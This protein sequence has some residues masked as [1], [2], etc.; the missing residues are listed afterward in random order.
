MSNRRDKLWR[1]QLVRRVMKF[2]PE[3]VEE[4]EERA[5]VM[6]HHGGLDRIKAETNAALRV[7][8]LRKEALN[9]KRGRDGG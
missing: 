6:E 5:A 2:E 8:E 4:F 7:S 3:W 9:A 1:D